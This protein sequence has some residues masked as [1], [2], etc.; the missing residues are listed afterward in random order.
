MHTLTPVTVAFKKHV[1]GRQV[2]H[3]LQSLNGYDPRPIKY[4]RTAQGQLQC[5]LSKVKGKGLGVSV[6][7]DP[8]CRVWKP[9][10]SS[11]QATLVDQFQLPSKQILIEGVEAFKESLKLT[12]DEIRAIERGTTEQNK[13]PL[14][15]SSRRYRLTASLF[16]RVYHNYVT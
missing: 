10:H 5:F 12:P 6:L 11:D 3:D 8:D 4:H 13:S 7:F 2:E 1:Y 14:W 15:Y 16:G 9:E